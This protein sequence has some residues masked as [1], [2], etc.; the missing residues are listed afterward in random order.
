MGLRVF[1]PECAAPR[2]APEVGARVRC[3]VCDRVF[4]AGTRVERRPRSVDPSRREKP[5]G[6][7]TF[8]I[9][10]GG[11]A[12]LVFGLVMGGGLAAWFVLTRE[13][14]RQDR[15][16]REM[17]EEVEDPGPPPPLVAPAH[18]DPLDDPDP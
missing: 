9:V 14:V 16:D 1:C 4:R 17:M 5:D 7:R 3:R 11:I 10:L 12:V 18:P 6:S 8:L 2:T 13:A 15:E